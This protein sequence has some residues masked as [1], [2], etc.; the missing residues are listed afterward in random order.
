[1]QEQTGDHAQALAN[2]ERSYAANRFQPGVANRI[3]TL[4]TAM[5]NTQPQLAGVTYPPGTII[6][7]PAAG[8]PVMVTTP[9][10]IR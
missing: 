10:T 3:G 7:A 8:G 1:L 6:P 2:Y 9:G 4:R 5:A